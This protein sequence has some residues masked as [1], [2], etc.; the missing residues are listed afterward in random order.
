M[1][2]ALASVFALALSF[3]LISLIGSR[4]KLSRKKIIY[5]Q[6]DTHNFLKEFF[7][8]DTEMENKTTQSKKRQEERG[9]KIIVT[10]DDKAYW[11][12]DNIFYTTNV[13]NGRPDFDNARPIDT[14]NMSKKELDKMLFILDNLGRGDKNE[15][16]SS[17]N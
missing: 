10:E 13:I 14:S 8:R 7:S 1:E 2:Y 12:I 17:G 16:G 6:S 3:I 5:R 15:R 4:K 9:T 11:V